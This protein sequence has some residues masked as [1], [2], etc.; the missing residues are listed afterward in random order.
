MPIDFDGAFDIVAYN[1]ACWRLV[2]VKCGYLRSKD[3]KMISEKSYPSNVI[4]EAWCWR[5]GFW[6]KEIIE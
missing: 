6:H 4:K 5:G 3:R 2:Q 1:K